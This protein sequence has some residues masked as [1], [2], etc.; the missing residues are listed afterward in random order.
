MQIY[1]FSGLSLERQA[2]VTTR[3]QKPIWIIQVF[4]TKPSFYACLTRWKLS[5]RMFLMKC[6]ALLK[7]SLWSCHS[8]WGE[9]K[10][11]N[12]PRHHFF[13]RKKKHVPVVFIF[14]EGGIR[15]KS[16]WRKNMVWSFSINFSFF[17][18]EKCTSYFWEDFFVQPKVKNPPAKC[19]SYIYI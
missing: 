14:F 16:W 3:S 12:L 8:R 13:S 7:S 2:P 9:G 17:G 6:P 5:T 11:W 10:R 4:D 18:L 19:K 15:P 1:Q